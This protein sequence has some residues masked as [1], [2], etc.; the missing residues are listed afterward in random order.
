MDGVADSNVL[1]DGGAAWGDDLKPGDCFFLALL[2]G[3]GYGAIGFREVQWDI[4]KCLWASMG[5]Y[6]CVFGSYA[7][8]C[9]VF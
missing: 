9:F 6:L 8:S 3:A 2:A 7:R 4:G 5:L 1:G